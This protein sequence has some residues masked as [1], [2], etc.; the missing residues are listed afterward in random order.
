MPTN[1]CIPEN[2]FLSNELAPEIQGGTS[3]KKILVPVI[4]LTL[5]LTLS[6]SVA[7][8]C[9]EQ[10]ATQVAAKS[11]SGCAKTAQAAAKGGS[12]CSKTAL[13]KAASGCAK[14]AAPAALFA[15]AK[16]LD[17]KGEIVCAHCDLDL[18]ESCAKMLRSG[19]T[20]YALSHDGAYEEMVEAAS[21]SDKQIKVHGKVA[22]KDGVQ[23]VLVESY[24]MV[25]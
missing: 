2:G 4:V 17:V 6:A 18:V 15:E 19:E 22:E 20:V 24:E 8:A 12:G 16:P 3:M 1:G 7:L 5:A 10:K 21:G 23:W 14:S 13:A 11:G 25:G 9:G